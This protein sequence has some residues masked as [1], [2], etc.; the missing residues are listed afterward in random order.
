MNAEDFNKINKELSEELEKNKEQISIC[1]ERANLLNFSQPENKVMGTIIFT[2]IPYMILY[3][4]FFIFGFLTKNLNMTIIDTIPAEIIPIILSGSSLC[5][6]NII[7]KKYY[8]KHKIQ[9]RLDSFTNAHTHLEKLEE[10][11]RYTVEIEKAENKNL[12]INKA[13]GLLNSEQSTLNSLSSKYNIIDK[14]SSRTKEEFQK[15]I[16]ELSIHLKD[17][18]DE[19]DLLSTQSVLNEKF[20][21]IRNKEQNFASLSLGVVFWGLVIMLFFSMSQ[22]LAQNFFEYSSSTLF[23]IIYSF[24]PYAIGF[25]GFGGYMT[26]RNK[27]YKKAFDNLNSELGENA[28]TDKELGIE[29]ADIGFRTRN[30]IKDISSILMQL[31]EQKRV[32]EAF[33]DNEE[34]KGNTLELITT[35]EH[36]ITTEKATNIFTNDTQENSYLSMDEAIC[37]DKDMEEKG[38]TLV[39]KSKNNNKKL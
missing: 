38:P 36:P 3:L 8:S 1:S 19:L 20:L 23:Q 7:R 31:H 12:A 24:A 30:T 6:G 4:L 25:A 29:K 5:I 15:K 34:Q 11:V 35:K 17:K 21:T 10:E 27:D 13:I 28:L 39:K 16:E 22:N 26:K 2:A 33:I 37:T 32:L 9:E 18:Y 14:N